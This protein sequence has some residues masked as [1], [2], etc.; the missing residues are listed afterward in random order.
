[1]W[2]AQQ[3]AV[4]FAKSRA[5]AHSGDVTIGGET[6]AV[7]LESE[8]RKVPLALPG[9]YFWLPEAQQEAFVV[10]GSDGLRYIVG[11]L[12]EMEKK[13][14]DIRPGES[15]LVGKGGSI[16]MLEDRIRIV[17]PECSVEI[18]DGSVSI[19]G[20]LYLNGIDVEA[21]LQE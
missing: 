4:N 1:M 2:L 13:D 5:G 6:P 3:A 8:K 7:M 17:T 18:K 20:K 21:A 19:S 16:Y 15:A 11:L 14:V 12:G 9:G 10:R